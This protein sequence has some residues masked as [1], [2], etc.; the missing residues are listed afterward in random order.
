LAWDAETNNNLHG[1]EPVIHG[2][3][4]FKQPRRDEI[5]VRRLRLLGHTNVTNL[6]LLT[7]ENP[8]QCSVCGGSLTVEHLLVAS[9]ALMPIRQ[10]FFNERT[11]PA[12]FDNVSSRKIVDLIKAIGF[13]R[14]K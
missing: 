10:Q 2:S 8:S 12:I 9:S 14:K 11:F 6:F 7:G 13:Y 4:S 1:I 3:V 5:I